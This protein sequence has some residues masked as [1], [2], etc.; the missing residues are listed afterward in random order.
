MTSSPPGSLTELEEAL[1][2]P[3][4]L[5][6]AALTAT[7]GDVLVIGAGGKMGPSLARMVRRAQ[8]ALKSDSQTIAVSRWSSPDVRQQLEAEG[9]RTL[10]ADV[11]D[12]RSLASLPMAPNVI[13]MA[14]QKFGT[15]DAPGQTWFTNVVVPALVVDRFSASRIVAFS[16]GNVYPL[17]RVHGGGSKESDALAPVG[18]YAMSCLGRERVLE[19]AATTHGTRISILRLNYAVDLRYGVLV[20]LA[21]K[22][23][24]HQ[25]IDLAM[26]YVNCIWQRDANAIAL[27][28]LA[29][30]DSPP[31]IVNVT[32]P[33]TLSVRSVALALGVRLGVEP[34]L[35][36]I[37]APDALLSNTQ[38][39]RERYDAT[40]LPVDTLVEWVAEWVRQGGVTSGKATRYDVRTGA[41]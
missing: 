6:L 29:D 16:T 18:E 12:P 40:L 38:R 5:V 2:R 32:G 25:P 11:G 31:W 28:A 24:A 19:R 41:F 3:D 20:D 10:T 35:T 13:F 4:D 27:R 37:E 23:L 7:P 33:D 30:S 15:Q 22:I 34:L 36:G 21:M 39:M 14:G 1:S 9:V 26:G 17:T 8:K